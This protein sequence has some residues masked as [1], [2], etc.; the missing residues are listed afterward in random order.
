MC[1]ELCDSY[2][3]RRDETPKASKS[4]EARFIPVF[5]SRKRKIKGL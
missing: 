4:H 3:M 1:Y 5:D 2:A